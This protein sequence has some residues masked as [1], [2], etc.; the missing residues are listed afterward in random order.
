MGGVIWV[1]SEPGQGSAFHFTARF[2]LSAVSSRITPAPVEL[3]GMRVL[4][5]DDNAT[6]RRILHDTVRNWHMHPVLADSGP[7]ALLAIENAA[8]ANECF[9]VL[10]LDC[11]MPE[12]TASPWLRSCAATLRS[13]RQPS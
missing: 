12:W 5:V 6:N 2:S 4:I 10:L 3:R 8:H 9:D 13:A 11:H 7:A 1:E